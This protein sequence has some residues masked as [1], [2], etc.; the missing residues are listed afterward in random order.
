[1]QPAIPRG[2]PNLCLYV[3][4]STNGHLGNRQ[5]R[6]PLLLKDI[7]AYAAIAVNVGVVD[8]GLEVYL[9]RLEGIVCSSI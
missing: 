1:M 4:N 6:T 7:E 9:W 8:L 5:C 2:V 3:C